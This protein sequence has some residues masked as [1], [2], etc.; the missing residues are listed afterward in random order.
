M[1]LRRY[2]EDTRRWLP[3]EL[4]D[5]I[6]LVPIERS[7]VIVCRPDARVRSGGRSIAPVI[8]VGEAELEFSVGCARFRLIVHP[9]LED[10][11]FESGEGAVTCAR[12]KKLLARG[13]RAVRCRCG[14][15]LHEGATASG[16]EPLLCLSYAPT[17]PCGVPRVELERAAEADGD[18]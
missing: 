15:L 9:P 12:C 1:Q 17:C 3:G 10:L 13:D 8:S 16:G 5:G 11:C 18:A 2:D 4:D 7:V 6:R 14:A